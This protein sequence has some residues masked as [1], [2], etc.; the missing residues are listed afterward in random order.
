MPLT[1]TQLFNLS[2]AERT[3]ALN[4][5]AGEA[6]QG[7][8]GAD[9]AAVA[10]NLLSRR[11]ANY[12]GNTNLV[13]IVK[14]PGQYEANFDLTKDQIVNPDLIS[15]EDQER[16]GAIFDNPSLIK[17]AYEKSGGA[18]SFRGTANYKYRRGDE[19]TPVEGKSNFYFDPLNPETYQKGLDMFSEVQAGGA[20]PSTKSNLSN[21]TQPTANNFIFNYI[22]GDLG[23]KETKKEEK[24][25]SLTERLK[26]QLFMQ[27]MSGSERPSLARQLINQ[28]KSGA[29][30]ANPLSL[31]ESYYSGD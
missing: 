16:I 26:E 17:D 3:A 2:P 29:G 20:L 13:D 15:K 6:Y 14:A 31:L 27:T 23:N 10:A 8:G 7:G 12:G 25:K 9:I 18:L 22:Y 1:T 11:L 4:T 5:I 30:Y 21:G 24:P 19:Y 28:V